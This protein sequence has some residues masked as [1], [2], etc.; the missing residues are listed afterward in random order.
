MGKC[1]NCGIEFKDRGSGLL[2]KIFCSHKCDARYHSKNSILK[3]SSPKS[4][5][6]HRRKSREWRLKHKEEQNKTNREHYHKNKERW[7]ARD[8]A[9]RLFDCKIVIPEKQCDCKNSKFRISH[10]KY[11]KNEK[12]FLRFV[13][14]KH[15]G[16]LCLNCQNRCNLILNN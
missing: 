4:I 6:Y 12:Q 5:E 10:R 11:A 14:G 7:V 13:E 3:R 1:K 16:F 8:I 15:I 2:K 9:R